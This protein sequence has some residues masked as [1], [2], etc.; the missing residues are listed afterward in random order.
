M[1]INEIYYIL[2]S[3]K[4]QNS[5]YFRFTALSP[6]SPGTFQMLNSLMW[7]RATILDSVDLGNLQKSLWTKNFIQQS[8]HWDSP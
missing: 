1:G 7:L 6:L 5:V 8:F 3:T 2:F 4:S